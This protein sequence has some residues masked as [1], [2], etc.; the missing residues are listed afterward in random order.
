MLT[1]KSR[2]LTLCLLVALA[3]SS[4][5]MAAPMTSNPDTMP[6]AYTTGAHSANEVLP[7]KSPI[8]GLDWEG[9]Y[10]PLVVQ[11]SNS[12]EARPHWNFSEADVVYESIYWGPGHT[13]YTAI[14]S[15]NH[16]DYVGSIRSARV[17]HCEIRQE[18]DA[19]FVFFGGQDT[20]GTSIYDFFKANGVDAQFR[21][22]GTKGGQGF[23]RESTRVNPH[24]AV[25][26]LAAMVANSWPTKEDGSPYEPKMHAYRFSTTPTY[27]ADTAKEI[28]VIYDESDYYPHYT[29]NAS[30]RVYERWYNGE[31]QYDGRSNKR[32]VA[33]NV[34]VQYA[35]L[36][37]FQN[38]RS[39]PV[40]NMVGSGVMDAFIDGRHIR[41][42]WERKTM[43]DRTVF[44]DGNGEEITMLPG[45]TF[46]QVI[47][48]SATFTYI[49]D[50]NTEVEM[51]FGTEPVPT[52]TFDQTESDAEI[53]KMEE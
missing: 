4:I 1:K 43:N 38:S 5:A 8:T 7:G 26:D 34:I 16:P 47:P 45:K 25:A 18:W 3:S 39:R 33:S 35:D 44:V 27:G 17:S 28:H 6:K 19:P 30:E 50:D 36:S 11:I 31:E 41:G 20:S 46:I 48:S 9:D 14:Y 22:D 49:R 52:A 37:Y 29:Y 21:I 32:I 24:N 42:S 13:R 40:I 2:L 12:K 51:A 23:S 53:D 10:R 15:D